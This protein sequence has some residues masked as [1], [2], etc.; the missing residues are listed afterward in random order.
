MKL[1]SHE[2]DMHRGY[3]NDANYRIRVEGLPPHTELRYEK[4][5][6]LYYAEKDGYVHFFHYDRPG[7]GYGG[8][9]FPITLTDGTEV[10]LKGPWSSRAAVMKNAGF[11]ETVELVINGFSGAVTREWLT[12]QG[13]ETVGVDHYGETVFVPAKDGVPIKDPKRWRDYISSD[14]SLSTEQSR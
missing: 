2:V 6:T 4:R 13:L 11:P 14:K 12:S 7:D 9:H 1:I 3:A 8:R 10:V 5:G